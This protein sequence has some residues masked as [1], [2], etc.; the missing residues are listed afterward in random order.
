MKFYL[1]HHVLQ[2]QST[3]D[4][5]FSTV[6]MRGIGIFCLTSLID[7]SFKARPQ[8]RVATGLGLGLFLDQSGAY[9]AERD[10]VPT[11]RLMKK[12]GRITVDCHGLTLTDSE[13]DKPQDD[14]AQ[15]RRNRHT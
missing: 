6:G 14:E 1:P 10:T 2:F 13:H 9:H 12:L 11:Q 7:E 3:E 8:A 15:S 5:E 4:S